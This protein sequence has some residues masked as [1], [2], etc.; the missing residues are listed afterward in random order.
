MSYRGDHYN[1]STSH[2]SYSGIAQDK[3]R[4]S[5]DNQY[6]YRNQHSYHSVH[7]GQPNHTGQQHRDPNAGTYPHYGQSPSYRHSYWDYSNDPGDYDGQTYHRHNNH[8]D[9]FYSNSS[10]YN[11]QMNRLSSQQYNGNYI[12]NSQRPTSKQKQPVHSSQGNNSNG[13]SKPTQSKPKAII[14]SYNLGDAKQGNFISEMN[15]P[16]NSTE[17]IKSW[18]VSQIKDPV[19]QK[20]KLNMK[21]I[22]NPLEKT[23]IDPRKNSTSNYSKALQ[24]SVCPPIGNL[25]IPTFKFDKYSL[26]EKPS[27]EIVI[28]N[29]HSTTSSL[30]I[31]NNLSVYGSILELKMVDDPLTAVPLGMCT[32]S[33]DG[34]VEQ[35]HKIALK[36]IETCNKKLLIQGRYIR[37]GL[38]VRNMLYNEIYEKSINARNEHLKKR[39]AEEIKREEKNKAELE[40]IERA[41]KE[42]ASRREREARGARAAK[43]SKDGPSRESNSNEPVGTISRKLP[44]SHDKRI[45][46]LS[47]FQLNYK[48]QKIVSNRP[49][50]FIADKHVSSM[51]V[52]SDHLRR[53]LRKYNIS[54]ILQQRSGFYLV[55]NKVKEALECFDEADGRR[56]FN[57]RLLMTLYI[58][59]DQIDQTRVGKAGVFKAAKDQISKE[60][61]AYLLKDVREKIISQMILDI[62][63]TDEIGE[64]AKEARIRKEEELKLIEKQ[65][66]VKSIHETV[67]VVKKIDLNIFKKSTKKRFVPLSHA[68]NKDVQNSDEDSD[69]SDDS[70]DAHADRENNLKVK[71][72]TAENPQK[73]TLEAVDN[74]PPKKKFK[75]TKPEEDLCEEEEGE[76]APPI[77]DDDAKMLDDTMSE[78][79]SPEN[80]GESKIY[81]IYSPSTNPPGP[82]FDDISQPFKPTI[83]HL[84]NL[85]KTDE[86]FAILS[87][88]CKDTKNDKPIKNMEFWVWQHTQYVQECKK[89]LEKDE[90]DKEKS[91]SDEVL[92]FAK[93]VLSNKDLKNVSGCF[94]TEPYHKISD[95]L[96]SGYLLHRRK[97]TN[98]NPVKHENKD[99]SIHVQH[100][101]AQGSRANRANTRRFVADIS[102][103]KQIIGET[104]LLDLNQLNKRKKPVQ[105]SRSAIHNWG[106]Y[107]LE[108]ISAGEMIIEYVGERI[109]QQVAEIREKKYLRSGIGSSYLFRV[110]ENTVIDASKKGGIARFINHCCDPSCTA[111]IIKVGGKKRIVIYALR[112]IRKN[113]ELT[114]DY[115]FERELNDQERIVC[116]CGSPNCKGFLN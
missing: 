54:R 100:N 99:E 69:D 111:K 48:L 2:S 74:K 27:N 82:V 61:N 42:E 59:D 29:L 11:A 76:Q 21:Y 78:I 47:A 3:G 83:G 105:F 18:K 81:D 5:T 109:R 63:E 12:D 45:L 30:V 66:P 98:L 14:K 16:F 106:L 79:T 72:D 84:R 110:D 25:K 38:N 94:R 9:S 13:E 73:H 91:E 65:E 52:S 104:D 90:R 35:A 36:V 19:T 95:N 34:K 51:N 20:V 17:K 22:D 96:K 8:M 44:L 41:K 85:V 75:V 103:Q 116:L 23:I 24:K 28:W 71:E 108:P 39:T 33:F 49:Y 67:R 92:D 115:K 32:V 40:R 107:A 70:D 77:S 112:D 6:S 43:E 60:L 10:S 1:K 46:P 62:L 58:P 37:C 114:Y 4:R 101:N 93:E 86:D 50:I 87:E 26:G 68:L 53:F 7:Q 102:A 88:L 57:Y 113:E 56:Y 97:L 89:A 64:F 55:F 31:K 15:K 80:G